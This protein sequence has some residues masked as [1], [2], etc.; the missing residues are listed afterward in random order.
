[1]PRVLVTDGLWRKSLAAVRSLGRQKISVAVTGDSRFTTSFYSRYCKRRVLVTQRANREKFSSQLL[2]ELRSVQYDMMF[3]MEDATIDVVLEHRTEFER[4]T[5][6]PLPSTESMRIASDKAATIH[7]AQNLGIPIPKT[8]W[9]D[10][11][12]E[13]SQL[14]SEISFPAVIKPTHGSGSR[15]L[16]Y[17]ATPS[18]LVDAYRIV[19][20]TSHRPLIQE[21]IPRTGQGV[22]AAMLF[23]SN[24][25]PVAGFTYK[26]IREYPINGGPSTLRESTHDP[27]LLAMAT[28][29]LTE[30]NWYGVA[31]VEFKIDPRDGVPR[32]MEINPRF[33]G[34]LELAI[35]SGV[36]FPNLLYQMVMGA[37]VHPVFSY[38]VGVKCRWLVPGDILHFLAD[39]ERLHL[40]PSFFTFVEPG[41]HYDDFSRDDLRGSFATVVC[42]AAQALRPRMWKIAIAR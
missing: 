14:M 25:Q 37:T 20:K 29:L 4:L 36:D 30:L 26:R 35:V 7:L 23:D 8:Y 21:L 32:L 6:I 9:P 12:V 31:M 41:L 17:A 2:D 40:E 38:E 13:L 3:P 16:R 1:M 10:S 19:N 42:T 18:E 11:D 27:E 34:S 39:P 22:G 24:H 33:W 28:K 5:R 15:G